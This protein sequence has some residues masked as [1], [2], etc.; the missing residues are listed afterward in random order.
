MEDDVTSLERLGERVREAQDRVLDP[1]VAQ[2]ETLERLLAARSLV[3]PAR[4]ARTL[5]AWRGRALGAAVLAAMV[6]IAV[7]VWPRTRALEFAVGA[8]SGR[9]H[10]GDWVAA[11]E[12]PLPLVFSDGTRLSLAA[13]GRVRVAA[14]DTRGAR[15]VLEQGAL[16]ASVL[17][18]DATRWSVDAGPYVVRVTGTRFSVS[19]DPGREE[20]RLALLEGSVVVT[21]PMLAEG[22][23]VAAG[24]RLSAS[25]RERRVAIEDDRGAAPPAGDGATA[26]RVDDGGS[27]PEPAP[28]PG[29][30]R[31]DGPPSRTPAAAGTVDAG[32]G[33][34]GTTS[35]RALAERGAYREAMREAEQGGFDALTTSTSAE[36]LALLADAAR[37]GG[38]GARAAQAL[39]ALR[40][41]FPG[42]PRAAV[43]AFHLG[44]L[45][46]D[47]RRAY[48]DAARWFATYL[49]EQPGGPFA[50][51]AA[52]R[53]VEARERGG[54]AE[55]A[56][57]AAT[58]YLGRYPSGPHAGKARSL[59]QGPA[60]K[61]ESDAGEQG[62]SPP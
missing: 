26:P 46:F 59:V 45:A 2:R 4:P 20:L 50:R 33:D 12:A 40:R 14:V 54:D 44:R 13:R 57:A 43:A 41:R 48:A 28:K 34:A 58:S 31:E 10:V 8:E 56:R 18:R 5:G 38:A 29:P 32:S 19:W 1:A 30:A 15:V 62:P 51:E 47:G 35:W 53:L 16:E 52:G 49:A 9:G 61:A 25:A 37:L 11:G 17:H 22:R 27:A 21:G 7:L 36:E 6:V 42:D 55:G 24:E 39:E 60:T 23:R 3:S